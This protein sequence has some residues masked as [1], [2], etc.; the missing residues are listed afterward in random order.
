M[1]AIFLL[2][3]IFTTQASEFTLQQL[4][5]GLN[6]SIEQ[7][8]NTT[9]PIWTYYTRADSRF[10]I[11]CLVDVAANT[12]LTYLYLDRYSYSNKTRVKE[13]L[14]M[15]LYNGR[16]GNTSKTLVYRAEL[17]IYRQKN[18]LFEEQ[19]LYQSADSSCG[20]FKFFKHPSGNSEPQMQAVRP[21]LANRN[22][23]ILSCAINLRQAG[24]RHH[25]PE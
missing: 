10:D 6:T 3:M 13:P 9:E 2:S 18:P 8:Y 23:A 25:H 20:V 1:Y 24:H 19:L 15:F 5:H 22:A 17:P 21:S 14:K 16:T 7:F 12:T 11:S 4:R